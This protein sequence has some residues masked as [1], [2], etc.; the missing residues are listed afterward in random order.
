MFSKILELQRISG[1]KDKASFIVD[2]TNDEVFVAIMKFLLDNTITTGIDVKKWD[3]CETEPSTDIWNKCTTFT[4][5][6]DFVKEN[7]TGRNEI[8]ATLKALCETYFDKEIDFI[9][10]KQIM[11]KTLTVGVSDKTWN[12]LVADELKV[13]YSPYMGC[14][15][16]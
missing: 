14:Q 4:D 13:P 11:T 16:Y 6:L 5:T 1:K 7:N 3:K 8:V 10:Y 12:K 2:N 15:S 9:T